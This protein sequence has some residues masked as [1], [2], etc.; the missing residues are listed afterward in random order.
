M[1]HRYSFIT[2]FFIL[3]TVC[4][5]VILG[6][7]KNVQENATY[8]EFALGDQTVE[9]I[10]YLMLEKTAELDPNYEMI[11][12]DENNGAIS[13]EQKASVNS[14]LR[15]MFSQYTTLLDNDENFGYEIHYNDQ[16]I[17]HN[18][19]EKLDK[20]QAL[21]YNEIYFDNES[22]QASQNS[23]YY[24]Y[25]FLNE[26]DL[27]YVYEQA[28]VV[29]NGNAYNQVYINLPKN[30]SFTFYIPKDL[31]SNQ[32][33]IVNSLNIPDA[34]A[35][36]LIFALI[37]VALIILV[38][39]LIFPI[40]I[41]TKAQPF[42]SAVRMKLEIAVIFYTS[43]LTLLLAGSIYL[44]GKTMNGTILRWLEQYKIFQPQ[45][46]CYLLN[47]IVYIITFTTIA[48]AY[49]Y[50]KNMI[51]KKPLHFLKTNSLTGMLISYIKLFL[52]KTASFDLA[53]DLN[54]K[55]LIFVGINTLASIILCL[56]GPFGILLAIGYGILCFFYL[57]KQLN[58]VQE[59]YLS[60]LEHA[61]SLAKGDFE[62][63]QNQDAGIFNS[64]EYE[65][66]SIQVGFETSLK[67]KIKSQ[68][69]KTE[70][71]TNVS[72]DLKT[73]LTGIK[74]YLE[75]LNDPGLDSKTR[76]EYLTTLTNYTDRLNNLIQDLF[77]I[78]K[79]NS[80]N[81]DLEPQ[82]I[83]LIEFMEQV[84]AENMSL[85]EE[86]NLI[87]VFEHDGED[88]YCTFDPDKTVRIFDNLISNI[89]KYT[90]ENTR[91]FVTCKKEKNYAT[92]TYKNISK[93]FLDFDPEQ[94]TERFVRGDAS[95]HE[96]GSGL[97]LAIIKSFAEIQ[98]GQ[99]QIE[100]D[101]DVFKAILKLPLFK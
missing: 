64:L 84:H 40:E 30:I 100:I 36:F 11:Q 92:I 51:K 88:I 75:L 57:K 29:L 89:S 59:D 80:G 39:V 58:K 69:L 31:E 49:V 55:L 14:S 47:F 1:K 37:I 45:L 3:I 46:I 27:Y 68:N 44:S 2:S 5:M 61:M 13:D 42:C 52:D 43:A 70:L 34:F 18:M 54:K 28:N 82:K 17:S 20:S 24:Y 81:I 66:S 93:T 22:V 12:F 90:L 99:F 78:S 72:H 35:Q 41:E 4:T 33:I 15:S 96:S 25:D 98:D 91:V 53:N 38:F 32:K 77:E 48:C 60:T 62:I 87:L 83:N 8:D 26:D 74:N 19:P 23:S 95:R 86:K 50:I 63:T 6:L 7:F 56:F 71:I 101:G 73:P 97:G 65:L 10:S 67:E 21:Y 9:A 79:A 94:I 76:N 85:L 16:T